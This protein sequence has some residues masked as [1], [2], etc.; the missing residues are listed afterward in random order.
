MAVWTASP[1]TSQF[2]SRSS[3]RV[4]SATSRR[5]RPLTTL[6]MASSECPKATPMLRWEDES[7]RS[8]CHRE[9]TSVAARVSS[10]EQEISALASA[11]SN[12]MGLTLCGMVE[13]PVAPSTGICWK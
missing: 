10:R 1:S 5:S 4:A 8:R 12:R 11:F 7:V 2:W 6:E 3:D 13:D 9:V